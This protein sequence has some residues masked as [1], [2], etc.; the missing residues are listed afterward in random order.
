[1][2]AAP[3]PPGNYRVRIR[4]AVSASQVTRTSERTFTRAKPVEKKPEPDKPAEKK[5]EPAKPSRPDE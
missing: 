2:L 1:V 4:D 3:L 5:P